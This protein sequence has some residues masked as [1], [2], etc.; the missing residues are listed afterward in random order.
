MPAASLIDL[1]VAQFLDQTAAET[2]TPGGG[3]V[4]ALAG[5]LAAALGGMVC[6]FTIG[7]PRF[8]GVESR[9]R[10]VREQLQQCER[11]LRA[12]VD[13][14]AAAYGRLSDAFKLPCSDASRAA[15]VAEAAS[16]AAIAPLSTAASCRRI[17]ELI[18]ELG[19]IGNPQLIADVEVSAALAQAA[20]AGAAA[21]V[22]VNL[23]LIDPPR[24]AQIAA[25]LRVIES[26]AG[27]AL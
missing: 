19:A 14:D 1:P 23:K 12:L 20:L 26:P 7:R 9:V 3:S 25:E 24:A 11:L 6:A 22:R 17:S 10:A 16:L 21:N 5:A 27:P 15:R 18:A 13:E 8:A 2:P 4:A